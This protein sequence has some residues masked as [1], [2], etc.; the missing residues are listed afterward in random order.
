[1]TRIA[2]ARKGSKQSAAA[3]AGNTDTRLPTASAVSV[4]TTSS[5][6][7]NGGVVTVPVSVGCLGVDMSTGTSAAAGATLVPAQYCNSL[8]GFVSVDVMHGW[9]IFIPASTATTF[10][11][12]IN[13]NRTLATSLTFPNQAG[14]LCHTDQ[15]QLSLL[16]HIHQQQIS[17]QSIL[18]APVPQYYQQFGD[19]IAQ[20]QQQ[21]QQQQQQSMLIREELPINI[22]APPPP[23]QPPAYVEGLD[24]S[25]SSSAVVSSQSTVC[26]ST[27]DIDLELPV[28]DRSGSHC[29]NKRGFICDTT[30]CAD[31]VVDI[32]NVFV[33]DD[34]IDDHHHLDGKNEG[35]YEP[36]MLMDITTAQPQIRPLPVPVAAAAAVTVPSS[37]SSSSSSS[38][39]AGCGAVAPVYVSALSVYRVSGDDSIIDDFQ[40]RNN[41]LLGVVVDPVSKAVKI[42]VDQQQQQ[43]QQVTNAQQEREDRS[44][45][46][47]NA[48]ILHD[49]A[50]AVKLMDSLDHHFATDYFLH[51][52][53]ESVAPDASATATT[54]ATSSD[55]VYHS[56]DH[57]G[58]FGSK[59]DTA[60]ITSNDNNDDNDD[61][62]EKAEI[63]SNDNND[64]NDDN[65]KSQSST[66]TTVIVQPVDYSIPM[67][68][69]PQQ[70][71]LQRRQELQPTGTHTFDGL[72]SSN[73]AMLQKLH[74]GHRRYAASI[75]DATVSMEYEYSGT[76]LTLAD[77]HSLPSYAYSH[78]SSYS[79]NS[80]SNSNDPNHQSNNYCVSMS[81]D[82]SFNYANAP[83]AGTVD[84]TP[85][86]TGSDTWDSIF[87]TKHGA[88]SF[89]D[90]MDFCGDL[91]EFD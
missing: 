31:A 47:N 45:N 18:P 72:D 15:Q 64:N 91:L 57:S 86:T 51:I 70:S 8:G 85:S 4:S 68:F 69:P 5:D 40:A 52:G 81:G 61:D 42:K 27:A 73:A 88:N 62:N 49:E 39:A 11:N 53:R 78:T 37:S 1:M 89:D 82:A 36:L 6:V 46:N 20:S 67:L 83:T 9:P 55:M 66:G 56:G 23:P 3:S 60:E 32:C 50:M 41:A 43:E 19:V 21:Q 79:S 35:D 77:F 16:P 26:I 90:I 74:G 71:S 28:A 25:S 14:H 76:K 24:T 54:T 30:A 12:T 10:I 7:S 48:A 17:Q 13:D 65:D 80:N 58:A 33:D 29:V 44:R 84:D 63:T 59:E 34:N 38:S 2:Q 75:Q 87:T 22:Q